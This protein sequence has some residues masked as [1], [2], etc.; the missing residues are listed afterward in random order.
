MA[1]EAME[2]SMMSEVKFDRRF[3]TSSLKYPDIHMHVA[4]GV[5]LGGL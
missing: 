5:H 1:S 3:E 4:P 2:A